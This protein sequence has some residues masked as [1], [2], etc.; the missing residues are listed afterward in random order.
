MRE[1]LGH[2]ADARAATSGEELAR[3]V[4]DL[5]DPG[6]H[7]RGLVLLEEGAVGRID[8]ARG[9]FTATVHGASGLQHDVQVHVRALPRDEAARLF[10]LLLDDPRLLAA[11]LAGTADLAAQAG[12]GAR[13]P[14]PRPTGLTEDDVEFV[15]SCPDP[16]PL[17]KHAVALA[18]AVADLADDAPAT[19]LRARGVPL[20]GLSRGGRALVVVPELPAAPEEDPAADFW[21]GPGGAP[22]LPPGL[23]H[24]PAT[25][26]RDPDLLAGVFRPLLRAEDPRRERERVAQAVA[27]LAAVYAAL[28]GA[29]AQETPAIGPPDVPSPTGT[30]A[31]DTSPTDPAPAAPGLS[32]TTPAGRGPAARALPPAAATR[33]RRRPTAP[34][35]R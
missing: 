1:G 30:S 2:L 4:E 15:C 25:A 21:D 3:L 24:R 27:G 19:W 32:A 6:R 16:D 18:L 22:V 33:P 7:D 23:W 10:R 29:A 34:R 5:A 8:V 12:R 26:V 14:P 35:P 20:E 13:T 11:L 17:C 9:R 31:T 28:A